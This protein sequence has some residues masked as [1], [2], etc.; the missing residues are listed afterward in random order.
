MLNVLR[1]LTEKQ[2]PFTVLPHAETF[3]TPRLAERLHQ[4][5]RSVVKT[6]LLR[7]DHGFKYV[8]AVLPATRHVDLTRLSDLLGRA[9]IRL[10]TR[11]EIAD[12]CPD[13]EFGVLPPFGSHYGMQTIVDHSLAENDEIVIASN[14]R[15]EAI[16]LK[17]RDYFD[18]ERPLVAS[19]SAPAKPISPAD[20]TGSALHA[21]SSRTG[22]A[23]AIPSQDTN[24]IG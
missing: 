10:A 15:H 20:F 6:V 3:D 7:A 23:S 9:E 18:L 19:F 8:L 11:L 22:V 1:F 21:P 4:P 24:R 13:C 14:A 12:C 16:R 17:Y 2:I 5:G